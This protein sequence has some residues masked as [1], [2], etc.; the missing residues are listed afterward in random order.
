MNSNPSITF[1]GVDD[2]LSTAAGFSTVNSMFSAIKLS[3]SSSGAGNI[4]SQAGTTAMSLATNGDKAYGANLSTN[5]GYLTGTTTSLSNINAV[6]SFIA[7]AFY[8]FLNAGGKLEGSGSQLASLN[9]SGAFYVGKWGGGGFY[10]NGDMAELTAYNGALTE[11]DK[12]RVEMYLSQKYNTSYTTDPVLDGKGLVSWYRADEG[13]TTVG[14]AAQFATVSSRYLQA[15]DS[16]S[17]NFSGGDMTIATWVYL[18][19]KASAQQIVS[20]WDGPLDWVLL[21]DNGSDS[22]TFYYT[23]DGGSPIGLNASCLGSPVVNQWYFVVAQYDLTNHTIKMS[24]N[25]GA[26]TCSNASAFGGVFHGSGALQFGRA[27]GTTSSDSRVAKTGLWNRLLSSAELLA[28]YNSGKGLAFSGLT[29]GLKS[30]LKAYWNLDEA[31]GSR[32]DSSGNSNTLTDFNSVGQA[33]CP[34]SAVSSWADQSGNVSRDA[35]QSTAANRPEWIADGGTAFNNKPVLRFDGVNDGLL[36]G[37]IGPTIRTMIVV[38][39]GNTSNTYLFS[40]AVDIN[41]RI[42]MARGGLYPQVAYVTSGTPYIVST[43]TDPGTA[44]QIWTGILETSNLFSFYAQGALS[45]SLTG[46]A[47]AHGNSTT[48]IGYYQSNNLY[49]LGDIAEVITYNRAL[50][51]SERNAVECYLSSKYNITLSGVV[52]P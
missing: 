34:G 8:Q 40:Q 49:W 5:V 2:F 7:D 51:T 37:T 15:A 21:Y 1:D 10:F 44:P 11:H 25:G 19:T 17:L 16:S 27:Y 22:F 24:L 48:A 45:N 6:L 26:T 28:L 3:S 14:N 4:L 41:N 46:T 42:G 47:P 18:G 33:A 52:C 39:A 30:N 12:Q 20:K 32:A 38:G 43:A 23:S 29:S 50:T 9:Q 13:I 31:S 36:T 35:T